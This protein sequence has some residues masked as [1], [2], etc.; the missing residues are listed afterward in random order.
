MALKRPSVELLTNKGGKETVEAYQH[1]G[2]ERGP[3][4]WVLDAQ[5]IDS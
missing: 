2:G 1:R 5:N 3:F 4:N